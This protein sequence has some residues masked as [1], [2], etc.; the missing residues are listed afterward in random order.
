MSKAPSY[1]DLSIH[2]TFQHGIVRGENIKIPAWPDR[3]PDGTLAGTA[4]GKGK[5]QV[6][7]TMR[8]APTHYDLSIHGTFQHG[9][10]AEGKNIKK[11]A[12]PDGA[13]AANEAKIRQAKSEI[14]FLE[15]VKIVPNVRVTWKWTIMSNF[16]DWRYHELFKIFI[17]RASCTF[18][19]I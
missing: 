3:A 14:I 2:G 17:S 5:D 18:A 9:I 16:R 12:W 15:S 11:P 7:P 8:K 4:D 6:S 1:C 13:P 19:L 10:V